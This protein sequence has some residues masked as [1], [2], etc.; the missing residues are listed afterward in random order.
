MGARHR[1]SNEPSTTKTHYQEQL[2]QYTFFLERSLSGH[3]VRD[4]LR[5]VGVKVETFASHYHHDTIDQVWLE[6]VGEK[7]WIVL[8]RDKRIGKRLLELDAL[9][10]GGVKAFA[11]VSG[12]LKDSENA[13]ILIKALPK[14]L[15]TIETNNFPFIAKIQRNSS[16]EVWK[17]EPMVHKGIQ[18]KKKVGQ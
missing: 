16:V 10:D 2:K 18:K 1:K 8:M 3:L 14:I 15:E 11:L 7:R 4:E 6:D 12:Q 9:L 13:A 5:K 17:T